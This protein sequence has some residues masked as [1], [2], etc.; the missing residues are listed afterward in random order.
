M[1]ITDMFIKL[2][3]PELGKNTDY[4]PDKALV[5]F[6][7][8]LL[9]KKVEVSITDHALPY[10]RDFISFY[11]QI[12]WTAVKDGRVTGFVTCIEPNEMFVFGSR[13]GGLR[14]KGAAKQ[15]VIWG[16]RTGKDSGIS[17]NTYAVPTMRSNGKP[18]TVNEIRD[19]LSSFLMTAKEGNDKKWLVTEIGCGMA[20]HKHKDI[21]MLFLP[22]IFYPN[23]ILPKRF[24]KV[25]ERNITRAQ[26]FDL[27]IV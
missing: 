14:D 19:S 5:Y 25:L 9:G 6:K 26:D 23:I 24:W 12:S 16:A 15:A 4:L 17:G 2:K 3:N 27:M 18:Y 21:A 10:L 11:G 1:I 20:G 22:A 13:S 7:K 8:L